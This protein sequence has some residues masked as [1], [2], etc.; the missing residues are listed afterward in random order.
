MEQGSP[1][2]PSRGSTTVELSG[3]PGA[4]LVVPGVHA[5]LATDGKRVLLAELDENGARSGRVSLLDLAGKQLSGAARRPGLLA[6]IRVHRL[7]ADARTRARRFA[8]KK[9]I[10]GVGWRARRAP[11]RR[12]WASAGSF[13]RS[14]GGCTSTASKAGQDRLLLMLPRGR[15]LLAAGSTGVAIATDDDTAARLY[16]LPRRTIDRT[17]TAMRLRAAAVFLAA[18]LLPA[19]APAVSHAAAARRRQPFLVAARRRARI[20]DHA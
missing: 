6:E 20:P 5:P 17:L 1:S 10:Q 13:T 7:A 14:G 19:A 15:T 4:R 18:A 9:G 8:S 11:A 3:A 2:C 16:R 12:R